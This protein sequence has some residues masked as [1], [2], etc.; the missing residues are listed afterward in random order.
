V[1]RYFQ[2]KPTPGMAR[3]AWWVFSELLAILGNEDGT[4]ARVATAAA[5][6]DRLASSVDAFRGLS[7]THLGL[8]GVPTSST[9]PVPA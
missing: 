2:A 4:E 7:Y 9:A 5:A 3:P 1:Q 8:A 6:F